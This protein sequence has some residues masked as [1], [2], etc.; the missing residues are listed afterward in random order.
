MK[1]LTNTTIIRNKSEKYYMRGGGVID[2]LSSFLL[3]ATA[4]EQ[5]FFRC[6]WVRL[7]VLNEATNQSA[8]NPF[9]APLCSACALNLLLSFCGRIFNIWQ[10]IIYFL[11]FF[12]FPF[13]FFFFFFFFFW[14]GCLSCQKPQKWQI[15]TVH[16]CFDC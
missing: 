11:G 13:S 3:I 15:L 1:V 5:A 8:P 6:M 14:G 10:N 16:F 7:T 4:A 12:L 2:H 9:T